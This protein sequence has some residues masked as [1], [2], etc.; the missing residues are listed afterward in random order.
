MNILLRFDVTKTLEIEESVL[1]NWLTLIESN[2][3]SSN[4]YH[5]STHAADVLQSSAYFLEKPNIQAVLDPV[6]ELVILI[7]AIVHDVDHPGIQIINPNP[8]A[9]RGED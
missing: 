5:N 7:G 9:R 6:D 8:T 3:H 2:Y 4:S 1:Q